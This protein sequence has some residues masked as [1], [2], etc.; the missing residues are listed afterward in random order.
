MK[1]VRIFIIYFPVIL[2]SFQVLVNLWSF[3]EPHTYLR[4]GFYLNT[5]FGTNVFFAIFLIAFTFS[6]KFCQISRWGSIAELLFAIN[7]LIVKEDN[8]YNIFF[9]IIIGMVAM[10]G[11]FWHYLKKFP[12]CRV[13]LLISFI[14]SILSNK[15]CK[16]G[17]NEW[18]RNIESIVVKNNRKKHGY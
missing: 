1:K 4:L 15:S 11:T 9:Q 10:I 16:N 8:L 17:L 7:F 3:L 5:F 6:F 12:L 14:G 2:V 13:S 18:E